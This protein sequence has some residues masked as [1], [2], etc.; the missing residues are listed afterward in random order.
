[1][2]AFIFD[3]DGV[4]INS[5]PLHFAVEAELAKENGIILKEGELESYV[6]TRADEMWS[7]L[8]A[9]HQADFDVDTLLKEANEKKLA[10]L[11]DAN[12]EPIDGIRELLEQLKEKGYKIGLGSSSTV[13]FIDAV[14]TAFS[15]KDQFDVVLSGEQVAK[16]KPA[17]DIYLAVA[18]RLGVSPQ[19]CTVL[20]DAAHGVQAGKEAG[21]TVIGYVNPYSGNQDLS[22]ADLRIEDIAA[23]TI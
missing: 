14:L 16:G 7:S 20:E 12:M 18:D 1:M 11:H 6:G 15:I 22:K 9:A 10:Y 19:N 5:E 17:P 13:A 21:M 23:I 4:I 2:K 8:K 3:M